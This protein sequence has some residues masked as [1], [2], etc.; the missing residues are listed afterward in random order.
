MLS[1]FIISLEAVLPMFILMVIGFFVRKKRLMEP[2]EIKKLN[3]MVFIVFFP[4]MMFHNLYGT[5]IE[6]SF[7]FRLIVFA[8]VSLALI[9]TGSVLVTLAIE[10]NPRSRGAMIQGLY[11]SNFVIMG[12]PIAI[13]MFGHGNSGVTAM[14][15]AVIV[16][17]FNVLAVVTLETFRGGRPDPAQIL[18]K[19]AANPLILGALAGILTVILDIRLPQVLVSVVDDMAKTAT[20]LALVILGASIDFSSIRKSGRNLLVVVLGRLVV[21]PA[22]G[23]TA[24]VF[25]GFRGIEFVTLIAMFAAPTAVSSFTMAESM[26]SDGQLAGSIV[27][28]TTAFACFT[29]FLWIFLFKNLGMF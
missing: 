1:N 11:R 19:I 18:K 14:V 12:L 29:M 9:Y 7:N 10:K 13:N 6:D 17:L 22:L 21:I 3:H 24:A 5:E 26:D 20:P 28:F 2:A 25:A 8:V 23:L 27:I 16:P 15:V 4:A